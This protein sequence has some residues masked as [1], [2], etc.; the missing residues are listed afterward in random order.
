MLNSVISTKSDIFAKNENIYSAIA[1]IYLSKP[2]FFSL[3]TEMKYTVREHLSRIS[4]FN[5][6][7]VL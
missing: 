3:N 1:I 2:T 7:I 6:E 5:A 4:S